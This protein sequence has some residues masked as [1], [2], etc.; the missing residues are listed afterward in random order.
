[1]D[2]AGKS[3]SAISWAM[4][5]SR[6]LA[7]SS[8]RL[9]AGTLDSAYNGADRAM[10]RAT[11]RPKRTRRKRCMVELLKTGIK[12]DTTLTTR[13]RLDDRFSR[14]RYKDEGTRDGRTSRIV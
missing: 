2:S 10:S 8:Y 3:L 13:R 9:A 11:R 14:P 6:A 12:A 1:M 4:S 5:A 7:T